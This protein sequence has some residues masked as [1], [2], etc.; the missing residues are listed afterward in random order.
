MIQQYSALMVSG[1]EMRMRIATRR[2]T[3]TALLISGLAGLLWLA[4]P[5]AHGQAV[6]VLH[7]FSGGD[8]MWPGE[9][10]LGSDGDLYGTT[11]AGGPSDMGTIFRMTTNGALTTL[12]AFSGSDGGGPFALAQGY[13]GCFYG[14]TASG[15]SCSSGTV[16]SVTSNGVLVTL[17]NFTGGDGTS[18]G[19][20]IQTQEGTLY[21]TSGHGGAYSLGTVFA[22][23]SNGMATILHAFT[24][25]DDG[26]KPQDGLAVGLDGNLYGT[27]YAGG[28]AGM[29]T[30]FRITTNGALTTL[31]AFAGN[32]DG[33]YPD[34]RLAR[35]D[36]GN[37][38]GTTPAGG[39]AAH[40]GTIFRMTT[41]G[42]LT[43]LWRFAWQGTAIDRRYEYPH[44][45]VLGLD[46][47]LFGT[48]DESPQTRS[49]GGAVPAIPP[50]PSLDFSSGRF[51]R[52][53]P[54]G[55]FTSLHSFTGWG[56]VS[57]PDSVV[58]TRESA[59]FGPTGW[60]YSS[61]TGAIVRITIP[62]PW[63]DAVTLS[64]GWMWMDWF[65]YFNVSLAPWIYHREHGW[66][67]GA[68]STTA[69]M[70]FWSVLMGWIWTSEE[71]YPFLYSDRSL[72][73]LWYQQ[74]STNPC[75]YYNVTDGTWVSR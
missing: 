70:W 10:V 27:T 23:T 43:T 8:G 54:T 52:M 72:S 75:W 64:N 13:D 49:F 50:P 41:N 42:V 17:H 28:S 20:L 31:Y 51:F 55:V 40:T 14:T 16:F 26:S 25:G 4:T 62:W 9:M 60:A 2:G 46:G 57:S 29:G 59:F 24:G 61:P 33:S 48:T 45:L 38:Y 30:V 21:G 69:D 5:S 63:S 44:G 22:V 15:G 53:T 1:R 12:Y 47:N 35:D 68:S 56:W 6:N 19:P 39:G 18:A 66:M 34:A 36:D 37:L 58:Q 65:G 32:G 7:M 67:Y 3:E 74:G 71:V 11:H 73:W